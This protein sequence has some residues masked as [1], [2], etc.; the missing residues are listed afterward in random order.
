[1]PTPNHFEAINMIP[2]HASGDTGTG[3]QI[4]T[5]AFG[6]AATAATLSTPSLGGTGGYITWIADADCY[7]IWGNSTMGAADSGG[8]YLPAG[9]F[10]NYFHRP[11]VD[12]YFSV[13]QKTAGGNLKRWRSV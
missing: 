9:V 10:V 6:A 3:N 7:V 11:M 12:D 8:L 13:I 4:L 1:M 5:T 2:P